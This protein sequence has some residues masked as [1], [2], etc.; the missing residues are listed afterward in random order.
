M[1]AYPLRGY[2]LPDADQLI[3]ICLECVAPSGA[4]AVSVPYV[5]P[6]FRPGLNVYIDPRIRDLYPLSPFAGC[7]VQT[8]EGSYYPLLEAF[9]ATPHEKL[10]PVRDASGQLWLIEEQYVWI[11]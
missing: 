1:V 8:C 6:R 9:G 7:I 2:A 5:H 10:V 3:W 11:D 4:E